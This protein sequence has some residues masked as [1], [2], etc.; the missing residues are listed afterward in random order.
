M[1]D[2]VS[3]E[4]NFDCPYSPHKLKNNNVN[5]EGSEVDTLT[6]TP[7]FG[8]RVLVETW[9]DL[10]SLLHVSVEYVHNITHRHCKMIWL[11]VLIG[12]FHTAD[13]VYI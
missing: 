1:D 7:P 9:H 2:S 5:N 8:C 12:Q 4:S 6:K 11:S 13:F 10:T 3:N